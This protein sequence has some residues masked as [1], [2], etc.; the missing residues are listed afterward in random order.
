VHRVVNEFCPSYNTAYIGTWN[1]HILHTTE[2]K[3]VNKFKLQKIYMNI[4][5]DAHSR[6]C[7]NTNFSEEVTSL[8]RLLFFASVRWCQHSTSP[9]RVEDSQHTTMFGNSYILQSGFSVPTVKQMLGGTVLKITQARGENTSLFTLPHTASKT[10]HPYKDFY[11]SILHHYY[12]NSHFT[13]HSIHSA[14]S[15]LRGESLNIK[16]IY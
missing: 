6:R 7:T 12:D 14:S 10:P 2:R 1:T 8:L 3:K 5:K 13:F 15:P 9:N 16:A 4:A 11:T